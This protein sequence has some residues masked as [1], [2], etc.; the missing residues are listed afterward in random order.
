MLD[1]GD[2]IELSIEAEDQEGRSHNITY[3][4]PANYNLAKI[5]R[6]WAQDFQ[7]TNPGV[8]GLQD[9]HGT[10]LDVCSTPQELGWV[11]T[12][13]STAKQIK[14]TAVPLDETYAEQKD[15]DK[16]A[17]AG[18]PWC[19]FLIDDKYADAAANTAGSKRKA[20]AAAET[21]KPRA[22]A[23]SITNTEK[24][25]TPKSDN[26]VTNLYGKQTLGDRRSITTNAVNT[27]SKAGASGTGSN[28]GSCPSG[29]DSV[30][31]QHPNPK[32]Q[33][34]KSSDRYEKYMK[35]KTPDEALGL[36]ACQGDIYFD[37]QKGYMK[38]RQK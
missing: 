23:K 34:T 10:L 26:A 27:K 21:P 22:V 24:L 7:I 30:S 3:T 17:L 32:R 15:A 13:V 20:A 2:T 4:L 35:A 36:G 37:W 33:G 11:A 16:K 19:T 14:L 38:R 25:T 31:F 1:S 9:E 28:S 18:K 12:K 8:V 29:S 5:A 6:R